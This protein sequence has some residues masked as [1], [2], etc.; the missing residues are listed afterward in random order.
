MGEVHYRALTRETADDFESVVLAG[1]GDEVRGLTARLLDC[2]TARAGFP[3]G[4]IGYTADGKP[5]CVLGGCVREV[6]W[7]Q[8]KYLATVIG[9]MSRTKG[10]TRQLLP[11][12]LRRAFRAT[13]EV[14]LGYVNSANV[15]AARLISRCVGAISGPESW[16]TI[17][18]RFFSSWRSFCWRIRA[19]IETRLGR[20]LPT[21]KLPKTESVTRLGN[22]RI[23]RRRLSIDGAFA[24]F[25]TR[26]LETNEGFVSSRAPDELEWA[27]GEA[28]RK[29]EAVMLALEESGAIS[30]YI[31]LHRHTPTCRNWAVSDW[32][33]LGNDES[34]LEALLEG[35]I[36]FLKRETP[37]IQLHACGFPMRVQP[38]LARYLP[39][40]EK[41]DHNRYCISVLTDENAAEIEAELF[42][43]ESWMFGTYD[44][45][46]CLF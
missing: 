8:E 5:G 43:D 14:K 36:T 29:G 33:A 20:P 26:Y 39:T 2:P 28:V 40:E 16:L 1:F 35:A 46:A 25:W 12:V 19:A 10:D 4:A 13:P 41:L 31:V 17:R 44:G 21:Y 42:G 9:T 11:E 27:F 15:A 38:L 6:F 32:I 7:K 30:G 3:A 22:G 37:A 24:D 45:D 18:S 34:R 23:L